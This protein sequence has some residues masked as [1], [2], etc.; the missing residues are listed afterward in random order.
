[1]RERGYDKELSVGLTGSSAI[2]GPIIPPSVPIIIYGMLAKQSIGKLFLAGVLPGLLLAGVVTGFVFILVIKRGYEREQAFSP[3][4]LMRS[5]IKAIPAMGVPIVIIGGILFGYTT[6]TEA[7]AIAVVYACLLGVIFGDLNA[8]ALWNEF[9][10][11]SIETFSLV[12]ILAAASIYGLVALQL[13]IPMM[14]ADIILGI[15]HNPLI[16]MLMISFLLLIIGTFLNVIPTIV[17]MTP[18]LIPIVNQVGIDLIHFG[19][20]MIL[21]LMVG[22]LTPPLGMVLFVLEKVTDAEIEEII[23]GV[24]PFYIPILLTLLIVIIWEDLSIYIPRILI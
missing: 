14:L 17:I 9:K 24:V 11:S 19:I 18:I 5:G 23:R 7:G 3:S 15:S 10:Y 16:V 4:Q 22:L 1:M 13:E 12:F 6:A 20:V 2:I 21:S 8:N